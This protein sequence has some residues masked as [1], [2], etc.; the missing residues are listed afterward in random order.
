MTNQEVFD[1]VW[2]YFIKD[3]NKQSYSRA[4]DMPNVYRI[5][6][7]SP[8]TGA[9]CALGVLIPDDKYKPEMENMPLPQVLYL[10]GFD[11]K[12]LDDA[13]FKTL[14]VAHDTTVIYDDFHERFKKALIHLAQSFSLTYESEATTSSEVVDGANKTGLFAAT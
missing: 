3:K 1:K 4:P 13:F 11:L 10:S 14:Q 9:K 2:K 8:E 6:Y 5:W 7:K 12:T